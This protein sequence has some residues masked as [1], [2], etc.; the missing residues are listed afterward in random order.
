MTA[1]IGTRRMRLKDVLDMA[2]SEL[3]LLKPM[4]HV[5]SAAVAA[6]IKL[7]LLVLGNRSFL[8][9]IAWP[10]Y[11]IL[12]VLVVSRLFFITRNTIFEGIIQECRK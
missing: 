6:T 12:L 9:M 10:C 11:T 2:I 3:Q 4:K 7:W 5:A 1:V 8:Q